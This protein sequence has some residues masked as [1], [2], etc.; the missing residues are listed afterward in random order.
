M[1]DILTPS[2]GRPEKLKR[3]WESALR[4]AYYP[5]LLHLRVG[6]NEEELTLYT[7]IIGKNQL[8]IYGVKDWSTVHSIN[9]LAQDSMMGKSDIFLV[10][11]DD[12]L[13][14]TPGWDKA[15]IDHYSAL[16]NK[17][18]VYSLRDSRSEHGTPHPAVTREYVE[19][20]GYLA[21][22]IFLHW[23]VDTWLVDIAKANNCFTHLMDYLLVHDKPSDKGVHDETHSRIRRRGW[24]DRDKF[25]NEKCQHFLDAEKHRLGQY[26]RWKQGIA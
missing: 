15:L 21:T 19:A 26:I 5:H 25:T 14:S 10:V 8:T 11:G 12:A 13:F 7:P 22:P 17:I 3:M 6:V 9:L 18:H 20:M 24:Y 1:I 4:T 16:E 23:F 2:R